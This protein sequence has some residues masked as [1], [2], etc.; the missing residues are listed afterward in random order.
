MEKIILDS[1][2][3]NKLKGLNNVNIKFSDT[4]TAIMGVNGSGKTTVIH[5]LACLYQPDGNGENHKFPEFFVPNTDAL[6]KGSK[7]NVVN[8]KAR[9]KADREPEVMAS[10]CYCKKKIDGHPDMILVLKEMFTILELIL[11]Y[12]KLKK[13]IP[14]VE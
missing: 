5:A 6:W 12:L 10:K 7:L 8:K 14:I 11:V 1:V 9:E 3:F 4:L 13:E 2:H